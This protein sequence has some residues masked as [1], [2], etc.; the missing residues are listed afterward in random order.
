MANKLAK[1]TEL[2]RKTKLTEKE[3]NPKKTENYKKTE[4][5]SKTE[6]S[7]KISRAT[8]GADNRLP[9]FNATDL[10]VVTESKNK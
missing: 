3:E 2:T 5:D 9:I 7:K 6:G 1:K 8:T 10:L 4:R